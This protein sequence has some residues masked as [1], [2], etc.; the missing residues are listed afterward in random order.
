MVL[1][2]Q[3]MNVKAGGL[4]QLFPG[5]SDRRVAEP[6]RGKKAGGLSQLLAFIFAVQIRINIRPTELLK[7]QRR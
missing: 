1:Q 7:R 3:R 2:N 5:L 6:T 4:S